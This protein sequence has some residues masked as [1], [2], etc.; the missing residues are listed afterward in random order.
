M[1]SSLGHN[2]TILLKWGASTKISKWKIQQFCFSSL[3]TIYVFFANKKTCHF[4]GFFSLI[5]ASSNFNHNHENLR[6]SPHA[7][8]PWNKAPITRPKEP[9]WLMIPP[10]I[11][12]ILSFGKRGARG[13]AAGKGPIDTSLFQTHRFFPAFQIFEKRFKITIHLFLTLPRSENRKDF[14]SKEIQLFRSAGVKQHPDLIFHDSW[15]KLWVALLETN[16][17]SPLKIGC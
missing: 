13:T 9:W 17:F 16:Q 5:T 7:T 4:L 1:G 15:L 6:D 8:L 10:W 12:G 3:V 11:A 14:V 2:K